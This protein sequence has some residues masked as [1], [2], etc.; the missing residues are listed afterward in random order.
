MRVRSQHIFPN[1]P[2]YI[3]RVQ[4]LETPAYVPAAGVTPPIPAWK[5]FPDFNDVLPRGDPARN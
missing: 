4:I 2:R 3:H 1:C 5:T